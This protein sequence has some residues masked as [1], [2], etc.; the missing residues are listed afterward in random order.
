MK[1]A[2]PLLPATVAAQVEALMTPEALATMAIV[3][4]AWGVSHFFGVGEIADA[5]MLVVGAAFLGKSAVDVAEDLMGFVTNALGA[6]TESDLDKAAQHFASATIKGGITVVTAILLKRGAQSTQAR[7][8]AKYGTGWRRG[9]P[10]VPPGAKPVTPGVHVP[11][12]PAGA[13][14]PANLEP[15]GEPIRGA[16]AA[17]PDCAE[18]AQFITDAINNM[19]GVKTVGPNPAGFRTAAGQA[20]DHCWANVLYNGVRYVLDTSA[21]QYIKGSAFCTK[22]PLLEPSAIIQAGLAEAVETGVFTPSQHQTFMSMLSRSNV[23][24]K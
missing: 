23:V 20:G 10:A 3:T 22:A 5:V 18:Q 8:D 21:A 13:K 1:R 17:S 12:A 6:K 4:T 24:M 16:R 7:L 11:G 15:L 9:T 14:L 2:L 19:P